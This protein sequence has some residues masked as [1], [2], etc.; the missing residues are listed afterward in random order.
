MAFARH[1]SVAYNDSYRGYIGQQGIVI[2]E[3]MRQLV[4]SSS[5]TRTSYGSRPTR[6][7]RLFEREIHRTMNMSSQRAT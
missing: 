6:C 5:R 1:D 4:E 2:N 7:V 3:D